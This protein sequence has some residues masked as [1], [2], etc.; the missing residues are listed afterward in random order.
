L[1]RINSQIKGF[2]TVLV[3]DEDGTKLGVKPI[4]EAITLAADKGKDLI[5]IATNP[6]H[7]ICKIMEYSK[8]LYEQKKAQKQPKAP[9]QKEFRFGINIDDHDLQT[10]AKHIT[11]LLDKNH[12]IRIVVRFRGRENA[13]IDSGH[14][15]IEKLKLLVANGTFTATKQEEKTIVTN[16]RKK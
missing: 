11:E 6:N 9:E 4:A 1:N 10:K 12:P 5:E 2:H 14:A 13:R 3:I 15:L 16:I 8:F 7:A